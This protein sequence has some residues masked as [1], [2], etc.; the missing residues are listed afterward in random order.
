MPAAETNRI[1]ALAGLLGAPDDDDDSLFG[2]DCGSHSSRSDHSDD[3]GG[4]RC[5]PPGA[6]TGGEEV[7]PR[8]A[9]DERQAG[10]GGGG[11]GARR[12]SP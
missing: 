2:L 4:V 10:G 8:R 12:T 7:P 9:Q 11:Q 3:R 6:M 5:G 1:K